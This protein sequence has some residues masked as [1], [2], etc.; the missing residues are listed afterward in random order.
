MLL[1]KG[2]AAGLLNTLERRT[3]GI[4][5]KLDISDT[6]Q[7]LERFGFKGVVRAV[8]EIGWPDDMARVAFGNELP[9]IGWAVQYQRRERPV[10]ESRA[11]RCKTS[12]RIKYAV[13]CKTVDIGLS[14]CVQ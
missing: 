12:E 4:D 13:Y 5:F 11:R 2:D 10:F 3:T 1:S 9:D 7:L 14:R 8:K 6:G